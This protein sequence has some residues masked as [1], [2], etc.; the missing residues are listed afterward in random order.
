MA[1]DHS[2]ECV[3]CGTWYGGLDDPWQSH[4]CSG[5]AAAEPPPRTDSV[6]IYP[7]PSCE[8]TD[9]IA[10]LEQ[11]IAKLERDAAALTALRRVEAELAIE[12]ARNDARRP[13]RVVIGDIFTQSNRRTAS[14]VP[15]PSRRGKGRRK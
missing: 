15:V 2:I 12:S 7:G 13:I 1:R 4:A 3:K 5:A 6:R 8:H 10:A 9:R 14:D 11:R